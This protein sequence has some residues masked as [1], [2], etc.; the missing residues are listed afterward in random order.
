[1]D[2]SV[3]IPIYNTGEYLEECLES[4]I[5]QTYNNYEVILIND[6]STDNSLLIA[7]KYA[8]KYNNIRVINQQNYGQSVA[9][10]RGIKEAKGKYIYF[11]D[12]DDILEKNLLEDCYRKFKENDIDMVM[13][14]YKFMCENGIDEHLNNKE[15]LISDVLSDKYVSGKDIFKKNIYINDFLAVVW[16]QMY[17]KSFLLENKLFFEEKI[18]YEDL[19]FIFKTFIKCKRM[20]YLNKSMYV[21]RRRPTSTTT[22]NAVSNEKY[23]KSLNTVIDKIIKY[24][25]D[26]DRS[27]NVLEESVKKYLNHIFKI[28]ITYL[29]KEYIYNKFTE[30]I[31]LNINKYIN[32][33]CQVFGSKMFEQDYKFFAEQIIRFGECSD[34]IV[35]YIYRNNYSLEKDII[36]QIQKDVNN[37]SN[38]RKQILCKTNLKNADKIVGIYGVSNHTISLLKYYE[39]CFGKIKTKIYLIDSFKGKQNEKYNG[40]QIINIEDINEYKFDEIIISSYNSEEI[41]FE[42]LRIHLKSDIPIYRF[43]EK[44]DILLFG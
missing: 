43:Y 22:N 40:F 27:D 42:K 38:I 30:D 17:K 19:E 10:N 20:M 3:I 34:E 36:I 1:M 35:E 31:K 32:K 29:N 44:N 25:N 37:A 11:A 13:F 23:I 6:G 39:N 12:S 24:L 28:L 33:Y 18:F 41:L 8:N 16:T 21:Y 9:R 26:M 7:N 14:G 15:I 4:V 2:I 5:N